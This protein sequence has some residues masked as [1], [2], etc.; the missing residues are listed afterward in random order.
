MSGCLPIVVQIPV[1]FALYKVMFVTIEM[2]HAP[3]FG[4]IQDL[5]APDPTSILNAF[6]LLP[7]TVPPLGF[8]EILSLGIWPIVMGLTMF[9]QQRLNPQPADPMQA[10]I[11]LFMPF[12]FT[13]L[14]ARF[15]A[16]LVIYWAWNNTLSIL[17]QYVIMRRAGVQIG[18]KPKSS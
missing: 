9:L 10:K 12:F 15:P 8:L 4:W 7:W 17:Q 14:L 13:F 3:F 1:F 18:R 11:F 16:G 2:R 6:G 5:S